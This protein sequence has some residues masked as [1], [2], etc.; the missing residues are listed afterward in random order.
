MS[1]AVAVIK[2][3]VVDVVEKKVRAFQTNGELDIP[4]NYSPSNA[5]KSAWLILQ[6]IKDRNGKPAVEVCTKASMANALLNMVVQGLNP[7]KNQCY[8]IVYG[9]QLVM[10]RS[11]FGTMHI[12]KT[13]CPDI[14]DIY[15]DVV[16]ADDVFEYEKSRGR[17]II[18]KHVQKLGN[19]AA[20]KLIAAYCTVVYKNGTEN[21]TIMTLDE[22]KQSWRKS[23][24][25]A[26]SSG[27]NLNERSAH[28]QFTSEMMK[29]TV[30]NR[31][32]KPIINA[33]DDSSIM[34][35]GQLDN[36]AHQ[37]AVESEIQENANSIVIDI[38][39]QPV[40]VDIQT[41]EV[42]ANDEIQDAEN[43]S[44]DTSSMPDF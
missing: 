29:K 1:D 40:V 30:T 4:V 39:E 10:Q 18:T 27:D 26:F 31:A 14:E 34:I 16:Y 2:K 24:A 42:A 23:R 32:C 19:V 13:V 36:E 35:S 43:T 44:S 22:C 6:D 17:T 37:I 11:Y 7:A 41:G 28:G 5:M 25:G 21:S 20:D 12:A 15:S 8:F 33:S 9:N 3:D 38:D